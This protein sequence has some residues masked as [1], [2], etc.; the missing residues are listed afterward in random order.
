MY[1]GNVKYREKQI[2]HQLKSSHNYQKANIKN[3]FIKGGR[4]SGGRNL[5]E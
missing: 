2:F 1:L 5:E 4:I 3:G